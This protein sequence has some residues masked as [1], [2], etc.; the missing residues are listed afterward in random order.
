MIYDRLNAKPLC[1]CKQVFENVTVIKFY[2]VK[3][4]VFKPA[5]NQCK[6]VTRGHGA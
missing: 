5:E 4:S 3:F 1:S 6:S 2:G